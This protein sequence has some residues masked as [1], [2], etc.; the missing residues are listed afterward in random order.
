MC[1]VQEENRKNICTTLQTKS[2]MSLKW[3]ELMI[4]TSRKLFLTPPNAAHQ[5]YYIMITWFKVIHLK[6]SE[7]VCRKRKFH[8]FN[9]YNKHLFHVNVNLIFLF[10]IIWSETFLHCSNCKTVKEKL[11]FIFQLTLLHYVN[12]KAVKEQLSLIFH[13]TTCLN[14]PQFL[15]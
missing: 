8:L 14:W 4:H 1:K 9:S 12:C 6:N 11:S 13:I 2:W 7:M 15:W 3:V 5:S 10:H